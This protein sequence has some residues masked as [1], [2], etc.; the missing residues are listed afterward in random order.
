MSSYDEKY[1]QQRLVA[2]GYFPE[3]LRFCIRAAGLKRPRTVLDLGGGTGAHSL[4]MQEMGFDVTLLDYSQ[5]AVET[6]RAAGVHRAIQADFFANPL[7]GEQFD[8][9][10]ARGFTGLNTDDMDRFSDVLARVNRYVALDGA[11]IYWSWTNLSCEWT[12]VR[13]FNQHPRRIAHLFDR[14]LVVPAFRVLAHLPVFVAVAAD[15]LVRFLPPG[16]IGKVS[17]LG[18]KAARTDSTP[19]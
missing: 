9:V 4:A 18:I 7:A 8:L 16:L 17:I 19:L 12:P 2:S 10:L 1:T 6:A 13:T 15:R 3:Q 11:A 14:V 5:V